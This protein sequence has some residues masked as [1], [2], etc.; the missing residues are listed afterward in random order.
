MSAEILIQLRAGQL[1]GRTQVKISAGLSGVPE[2]ILSLKDTLEILDL[3]GNE[4][5]D[6]PEWMPS[7][8][9][10]RILFL[11]QNPLETVPEILGQCPALEMMGF[12]SCRIQTVSGDSLPRLLRW[13][14]L[15]DNCITALPEELGERPL[16]QKLMLSGNRLT[17]LPASLSGAPRLELLRLA[18]NQFQA[19]PDWLWELPAL[20]WL[21]IAGN[22]CTAWPESIPGA[23]PAALIPWEEL[24]IGALLGE[25]ASGQIHQAQWHRQAGGAPV[26][27]AVKL[28]KGS[29]TSD[30]LPAGEMSASLA[31]ASHPGLLGA[32]GRIDRHPERKAGLV[33]RLIPPDFRSLA[34]PPDYASCTRDI[35]GPKTCFT[36]QQISALSLQLAR[37]GQELHRQGLMHGDF[38]A[39]NVL[40]DDAGNCVLGDFGAASPVPTLPA[41][42]AERLEVRAW[43]ILVDELVARCHPTDATFAEGF[44]RIAGRCTQPVLRL[45]PDFAE[46]LDKLKSLPGQ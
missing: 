41:G 25:G 44:A 16:L 7:L 29:M 32:N 45:R 27:V 21:A 24:E 18:A 35:Y 8:G 17:S 37:A 11:S 19:F 1:A 42:V 28:F 23:S 2:E 4:L 26:D 34:Q 14:I 5:T 36:Q 15:T 6:L 22:P 33:L 20:A 13:L 43:G 46:I 9:K 3:S 40:H 30:G 10:L 31:C 39:H 38:Y 12:K